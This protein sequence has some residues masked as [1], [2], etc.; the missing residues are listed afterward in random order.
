MVTKKEMDTERV[1]QRELESMNDVEE[2]GGYM[3]VFIGKDNYWCDKVYSKMV[4]WNLYP[5]YYMVILMT[6]YVYFYSYVT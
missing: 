6:I 3:C 1:S 2:K 4:W 5:T